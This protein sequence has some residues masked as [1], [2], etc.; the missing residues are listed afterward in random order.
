MVDFQGPPT[1]PAASQ[2]GARGG[3]L[4]KVLKFKKLAAHSLCA[5]TS[6]SPV[7]TLLQLRLQDRSD[8]KKKK[9]AKV[10]R[11]RGLQLLSSSEEYPNFWGT[12][13]NFR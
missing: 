6:Q 5:R 4:L 13:L 1:L 10:R 9:F 7:R 11:V 12:K 3:E 2:V 8:G